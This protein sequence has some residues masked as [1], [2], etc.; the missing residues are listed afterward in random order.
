MYTSVWHEFGRIF[1]A[2]VC[3]WLMW[4]MAREW[5]KTLRVCRMFV[6]SSCQGPVLAPS[7][8]FDPLF[9]SNPLR[10]STSFGSVRHTV[11]SMRDC[12]SQ[13]FSSIVDVSDVAHLSF[14][15]VCGQCAVDESCCLL[16]YVDKCIQIGHLV[17]WG[18]CCTVDRRFRWWW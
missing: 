2:K 6:N 8:L 17:V 15:A 14:L 7:N 3:E 4:E 1:L 5:T 10:A 18:W 13:G 16:D 11:C 9:L 12:S